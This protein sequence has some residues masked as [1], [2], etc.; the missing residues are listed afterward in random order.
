LQKRNKPLLARAARAAL[1]DSLESRL[2]FAAVLPDGFAEALVADGLV[3]PT[4]MEFAPDGR[5]FVLEKNGAVRI[6]KNG[7]LLPDAFI[8]LQVSTFGERGLGGIAFDPDFQDNK[9][10][11]LYYTAETPQPHNVISRFTAAGDV[12]T[13]GSQQVIFELP[14]GGGGTIHNG[15]AMRFAP[16]GTLMIG[17]GDHS[18]ATNAQ[19]MNVPFGKILRIN[20]DGSIPTDNPFLATTTGVNQAIWALGLRNP[21]TMS[22]QP[23]TGRLFINDVGQASW[24]EI[25]EAVPGANYGWPTTEGAFTQTDFPNFTNPIYAYSHDEGF[26]VTGGTFYNPPAVSFPAEMV[27]Q[28]FFA[29]YVSGFIRRMNPDTRAVT[30]FATGLSGAVDLDV[31]PDGSLYYLSRW[32]NSVLKISATTAPGVSIQPQSQLISIGEP[33]TFSVVA[34]GAAPLNYQWKRDGLD[35]AGATSSSY[36]IASTALQDSGATFACVIT[37]A[38]G[39]MQTNPA[40][41]TVT[42]DQPPV[43]VILTPIEGTTYGGGQNIS[44]SGE[45]TDNEDGTLAAS[46]MTWW[47]D[48]HHGTHVHPFLPPATGAGGQFE[49]PTIGETASNVWYRVYLQ[50]TDSAGFTRTTY[51]DIQPRLSTITIA[52]TFPGVTILFDGQPRQTPFTITGVEG[53]SRT[54]SA[55]A[56]AIIDGVAQ[57]FVSWSDGESATHMLVFPETDT[58][59]TATYQAYT[60]YYLSDRNSSTQSGS[61][62][63][64]ATTF[65]SPLALDGITYQKGLGAAAGTEV[66]YSLGGLYDRFIS[67]IGRDDAWNDLGSVTFEV[68]VDGVKRFDSGLMTGATPK[69]TVDISIAGA[70][71]L[72][73]IVTD[74]GDGAGYDTADW[75]NARI[76]LTAAAAPDAP[77]DLLAT[78]PRYNRVNLTWKDR[79]SNEGAFVVERSV[80]SVDFDPIASVAAGV[81]SYIDVYRAAATTYYYRV[82]ATNAVGNSAYSVV[83]SVTTD[84]TTLPA[85]W[86]EAGIGAIPPNLSGS[87]A[88]DDGAFAVRGAGSDVGFES[89]EFH[90]VY[91]TLAGDGRLIAR[92]NSIALTNDSAKAGVMMRESLEEDSRDV[93]MYLTPM[94]NAGFMRRTLTGGDSD[95]TLLSQL[96]M[97]YWVQLLREGN[98]FTASYSSD[99]VNWTTAGSVTIA[100]GPTIYVG[101]AATSAY[102][103]SITTALFDEVSINNTVPIVVTPASATPNPITGT[104]GALSV[105]ADDDGGE[106]AL[107]YTWSV[108]SKPAGAA[109]PTFSVNGTNASKNTVA[110]FTQTGEY[111]LRARIFD[112]S[113]TVNSD[114]TVTVIQGVGSIIVT[115]LV[116]GPMI[117]DTQRGFSA[118]AKDQ[119]GAVM[120][121]QPTFVWST[122]AGSI[123]SAGVLTAPSVP[124][125]VTV[126]ATV[127]GSG[128]NGS[129]TVTVVRQPPSVLTQ[130]SATINA[131]GL[132]AALD[133]LAQSDLGEA[134]LIYTWNCTQQPAGAA[135]L[136]S[137]NGTNPAKNTVATFNKLGTYHLVVTVSDGS[138]TTT[139]EMDVII[140]PVATAVTITPS[141]QQLMPADVQQFAATE[142]DQFGA[143]MPTQPQITWSVNGGGTIDS[144]GLFTAGSTDGAFTVTASAV[145]GQVSGTVGFSVSTPPVVLNSNGMLFITGTSGNDVIVMD[146]PDEQLVVTVNGQE[147]SFDTD[148]VVAVTLDMLGGDDTLRVK[149]LSSTFTY[150]AGAG[151]DVINVDSGMMELVND[152]GSVSINVASG[153]SVVF[154]I[155]Q[156]LAALNIDGGDVSFNAPG[157]ALITDLLTMTADSQLNITSGSL[158]IG[159]ATAGTWNGTTYSDVT[160]WIDPVLNQGTWQSKGIT[161]P[162]A[163]NSNGQMVVAAAN[164]SDLLGLLP[165]E[166]SVWRGQTVDAQSVLVRATYAGDANL[167]GVINADDYAL[168]DFYV[169]VEGSNGYF[170]GDFNFDGDINADD[171]ALIDFYSTADLPLLP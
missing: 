105:L 85:P 135:V 92:V 97:P 111:T 55:E 106:A 108:L 53:M 68:W 18:L 139:A 170:R 41:L 63:L 40:T 98:E 114:V 128:M 136:F 109:N 49:V 30:P 143:D 133:V 160:G 6:I 130:P 115:P 122:D 151:A 149:N 75:A 32:T 121:T 24:E 54:L 156:H 126:S 22:I 88:F 99:G 90:F 69:Q 167:D 28:Y 51:R 38:S 27:G 82:R 123:T 31:G 23:S 155:T 58:T 145:G 16:D 72:K 74:G 96:T 171:Y 65:D 95:V 1:F 11:Y 100:M 159:N 162:Q 142:T 165:G 117:R 93:F 168:I 157:V 84:S 7:A 67:D 12:A 34:S 161:S 9:Y 116:S 3:S 153:A 60:D 14:Y 61:L 103:P 110:T 154:D 146:V 52:S 127:D 36:T 19:S 56:L 91:Q 45:A 150:L 89:D 13:P 62:K 132:S 94:T 144:T 138:Y 70:N 43:P 46:A 80:N 147:F 2:L 125:L 77:V 164:A 10:V 107:T 87:V 59:Y 141:G 86:L 81:T 140:T 83:S 134:A 47:I 166:T 71:E 78:T 104:T 76:R 158:I 137:E 118:V 4:A 17:V 102:A 131:N 44:F 15:G 50:V 35:I 129:A 37:N 64:D 25:N 163:A 8:N 66:T 169:Q 20:P 29:D 21:F 152:A 57:E 42:A 101:L 5:L 113:R 33:V 73:L 112:G 119:F 124:G 48:F 148:D 79:S 120:G 26:A 39:S